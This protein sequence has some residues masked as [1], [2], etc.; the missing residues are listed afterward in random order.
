MRKGRSFPGLTQGYICPALRRGSKH[1]TCTRKVAHR[2]K[3]PNHPAHPLQ[4]PRRAFRKPGPP[5][6]QPRPVRAP[7][8]GGTTPAALE[9]RWGALV[10]PAAPHEWCPTR[11]RDLHPAASLSLQHAQNVPS[12]NGGGRRGPPGSGPPGSGRMPQPP[13]SRSRINNGMKHCS[14]V[15]PGR[16]AARKVRGQQGMRQC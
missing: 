6:Q 8:A 13:P 7:L 2:K 1:T 16:C 5:T 12:E 14:A 9:A 15:R 11:A 10:Q 3:A 4:C